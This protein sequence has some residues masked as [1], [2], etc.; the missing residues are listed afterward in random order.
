LRDF[1]HGGPL[2]RVAHL[3]CR[4]DTGVCLPVVQL[5]PGQGR[6]LLRRKHAKM[7]I[8]GSWKIRAEFGQACRKI[9]GPG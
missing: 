3:L 9:L 6:T 2:F 8:G 4:L 5:V 1:E 7:L